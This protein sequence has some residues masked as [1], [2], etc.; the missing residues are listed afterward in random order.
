MAGDHLKD[1]PRMAHKSS[2]FRSVGDYYRFGFPESSS[3]QALVQAGLHT[4]CA[5]RTCVSKI[6]PR[7]G[8]CV[9]IFSVCPACEREA[10]ADGSV[11]GL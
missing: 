3:E 2:P 7:T 10:R 11:R 5:S 9:S 4:A 1:S 6:S 8:P